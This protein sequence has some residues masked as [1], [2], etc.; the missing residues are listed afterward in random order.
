MKKSYASMDVTKLILSFLVVAIHV[1]PLG[2]EYDHLRFPLTRIAVPLFF[3]IS[4]FL[5]FSHLPDITD[6]QGRRWRLC[7][8]VKRNLILY[9]VWFILLLPL[10]CLRNGYFHSN[11]G[12][13]LKDTVLRLFFGSTFPASWYITA[14]VICVVIVYFLCRYLNN[15]LILTIG[16]VF[17]AVCI[18]ASNYRG[19]LDPDGILMRVI[20][21]YPLSIYVG[22]P[23]GL[24]WVAVG[25][26]FADIQ[27]RREE[28]A[29]SGNKTGAVIGIT[30]AVML[31]ILLFCEQGL[32]DKLGS[33]YRNDCYFTLMLLCPVL[34]CLVLMWKVKTK[35]GA[36]MRR[37][38]T[39]TYCSHMM[40]ST[41][42]G[43]VLR[44]LRVSTDGILVSLCV[45]IVTVVC[46][47]VLSLLID[48]LSEKKHFHL[49]GYLR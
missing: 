23:A 33:S 11:L 19:V 40:I 47:V 37:M 5:F 12:A 16:A 9:F 32:I 14:T 20:E 45:Y 43:F 44:R 36:C 41:V 4:G 38:S 28:D 24:Y 6:E 25:K 29:D 1:N 30:L 31:F 17:Y 2:A 10:T 13:I 35:R 7:T 27:R 15:A 46:C 26:T 22:F 21:A 39:V 48:K 3:I 8:F 18:A 49:L 42:L 34:F